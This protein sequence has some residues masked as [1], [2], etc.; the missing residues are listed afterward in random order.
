MATLVYGNERNDSPISISLL[1]I[2]PD[3]ILCVH[4]QTIKHSQLWLFYYTLILYK[5]FQ[6]LCQRTQTFTCKE[7]QFANLISFAM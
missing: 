1:L 2:L 6:M 5:T 7:M 4:H 3:L